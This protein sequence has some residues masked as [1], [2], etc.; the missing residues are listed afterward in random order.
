MSAHDDCHSRTEFEEMDADEW[1]EAGEV[2][3]FSFSEP[4]VPPVF[5]SSFALLPFFL[6]FFQPLPGRPAPAEQPAGGR[7][8]GGNGMAP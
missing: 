8:S 3:L 2:S 7:S 1:G 4:P 5:S 6:P